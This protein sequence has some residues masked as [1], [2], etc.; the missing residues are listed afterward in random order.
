MKPFII[1]SIACVSVL[2]S[3]CATRVAVRPTSQP[4]NVVVVKKANPRP[5]VVVVKKR[6][7]RRHRRVIVR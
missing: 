6:P 4:N 7:V 5:N 3:S 2:L 1:L